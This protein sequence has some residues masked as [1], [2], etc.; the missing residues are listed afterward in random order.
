[1][2]FARPGKFRW[3][4]G[5]PYEQLIVGDGEKFWLYDADLEGRSPCA[6]WM[7]HWAATQPLALR[8]LCRSGDSHGFSSA[9]DWWRWS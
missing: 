7:P 4:Y 6:N 5:K 3:A 8:A 1:M 9:T 2:R